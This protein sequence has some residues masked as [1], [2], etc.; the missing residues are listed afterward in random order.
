MF[1]LSHS[2]H[3]FLFYLT[4]TDPFLFFPFTTLLSLA[5]HHSGDGEDV[6]RPTEEPV[7]LFASLL[8]HN[9]DCLSQNPPLFLEYRQEKEDSTN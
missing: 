3:L 9:L 7:G 8:E 1:E 4:I 2:V 5:S 6:Q